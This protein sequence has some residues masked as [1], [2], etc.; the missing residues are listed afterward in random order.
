[1]KK[2]LIVVPKKAVESAEYKIGDFVGMGFVLF[3]II[4]LAAMANY[5]KNFQYV[6]SSI[7]E[8]QQSETRTS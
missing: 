7:D 4:A 3:A 2:T 8:K 1:M 6:P 5:A